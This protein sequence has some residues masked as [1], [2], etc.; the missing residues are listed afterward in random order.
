[1]TATPPQ[2]TFIPNERTRIRR[3]ERARYD[4]ETVHAVLDEALF[5]HVGFVVD[6]QPYV[7]P[8]VHARVG[9]AL[10]LHGSPATRMLRT[11]KRGVP[12]CVTATLLDGLVLARSHFHH[13]MNYRSAVVVGTA[14]EVT[15]REEK[16]A[17]L[18][19]L[20]EHVARGRSGESRPPDDKEFRGTSVLAVPI[21]EAS[22]KVRTGG[23]SDDEADLSLDHWAGVLPVRLV[24]GAPEADPG[25]APGTPLPASIAAWTRG[26]TLV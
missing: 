15:D 18:V 23:P 22:A 12:I 11:L 20:V 21:E 5:C 26:R 16:E 7:I 6:A 14:R 1:M 8:T 10:Y 24:A 2:G 9:E 3:D 19:A 25:L 4:R 13:T 17:A